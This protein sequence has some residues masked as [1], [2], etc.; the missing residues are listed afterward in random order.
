MASDGIDRDQVLHVAR[1]AR[2]HLEQDELERMTEQLGQILR[3][4]S[5][6]N[7]VDTSHLEATS[8]VGEQEMRL[9]DDDLHESLDH[10]QI[11]QESPLSAHDGFVVPSF[12]E[13]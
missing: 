2:L 12:L 8:Q 1:L 5:L 11:L 3:Y 13:Q 9:R 4:V 10:D 7:E 6:L